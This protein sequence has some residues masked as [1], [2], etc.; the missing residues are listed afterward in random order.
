MA[1]RRRKPY[2]LR[3]IIPLLSQEQLIVASETIQNSIFMEE[4]MKA[5]RDRIAEDGVD[6][7]Y[8]YGTKPTA[9]MELYLKLQKQYVVNVRFLADLVPQN[10]KQDN[11][12][13]LEF[14]SG[15]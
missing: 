13:L 7:E 3:E 15:K 2:T 11:D 10:P 4:Q 8:Q 9:A 12:E 1:R 14:L 6:E 5:L